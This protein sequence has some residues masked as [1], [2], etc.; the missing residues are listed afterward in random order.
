M[1]G[2]RQTRAGDINYRADIPPIANRIRE[3]K[4]F[5]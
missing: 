5:L 1:D 2:I 3:N 4:E